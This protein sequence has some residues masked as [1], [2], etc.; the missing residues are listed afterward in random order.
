MKNKRSNKVLGTLEGV[1]SR[2]WHMGKG[3]LRKHQ[4]SGSRIQRK[5]KHKSQKTEEARSS[6]RMRLQKE[7]VTR[8]VYSKNIVWMG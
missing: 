7:E 8:K 6:R 4:E 3:E 5:N 1:H 2:I